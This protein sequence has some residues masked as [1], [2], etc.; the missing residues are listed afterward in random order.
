MTTGSL[1]LTEIL[2]SWKS[3]SSNSDASQTRRLDQRLGRG[4]AVLR[5]QPRVERPGVDADPDGDA[6]VL[7]GLRDLA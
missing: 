2:K 1:C 5:E 7:G 3:C 6:G 4:L